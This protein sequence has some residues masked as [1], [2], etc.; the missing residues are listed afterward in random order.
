[1]PNVDWTDP[2]TTG[3][4]SDTANWTGLVGEIYPG[5]IGAFGD[6]VTIGASN[7]AYVVTFNV[8][9]ATVSSLTIEG[10]NG[11]PHP[12]ILRMTAGT[13]LNIAGGVTLF[14]KDSNASI[15][16]AGTLSVSGGITTA[17]ATP[18]EGI[19]T[20]GTDT[21]GG[22]LE[23]TGT[24]FIT[25][26][27]VFAISA[28]A[29][30]TLAF[31][32]LGGVQTAT[33]ITINNVNQTL[34]IGSLGSL[35]IGTTQ[36]VTDGTIV[37]A[38]GALTDVSGISFGTA[39]SSGSLSGYGTITG[40][41]TRSGSGAANTITAIGGNLT[42]STAI[43]A[44]SGL[45]FAIG[46]TPVSA[47]QL[48]ADPGDGNSFTFLGSDGELALTTGAAS[49]FNN[50]I[51]GLDVGTTLTPTN[52]VHILDDPTVT[53]ASGQVGSGTTGTVTLSNGAVLSLGGITNSGSGWFVNTVSDGAGGTEVFL[54]T[55][56]CYL[57]G[58][59][60]LTP[61]GEVCVE[62]LKIGDL[63]VTRFGAI[64]PIKWIG[65]QSYGARF[66]KTDRRQVP[67]CI[68]AG[69]LGDRQP[70]RDLFVSPGHSMLIDGHLVL[71]RFLVNG[72]TITQE[73]S[74]EDIHYFQIELDTHDCV[75]AE[76]VWSETFA[77]GP[78]LRNQFHNVAEFAA[79]YPD[80]GPPDEISLCAPRP[81]RGAKLDKVLRSV[82][83]R[84]NA[85][86]RPGPLQGAIDM[87]AAPWTIEGWAN[88][89]DHPELPVLLEILMDDQVIGTALACSYRRDLDKVGIGAGRCAFFVTSPVRLRPDS[90]ESLRIRR[91]SDH[92]EIAMTTDCVARIV[93]DRDENTASQLRLI[94]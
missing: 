88:D 5:Q 56:I 35:V 54:S 12:T 62:D 91:A 86:L 26:P 94:A 1:M 18:S 46:S 68:R 7:S 81:E 36:N 19:I 90:L 11:T 72:V 55:A 65:R 6:V 89:V 15:D 27:F 92:A 42:L 53:V 8:P 10:G 32:L 24:G 43:G 85:G 70:A 21:T 58:T 83:A 50:T 33:A 76:G 31:N 77:D 49:G 47:L 82:V 14:K 3:N 22:V 2:G 60:I 51:V 25:T 63:V 39:T 23:L 16:G 40:A 28:A 71:A 59:H 20:A 48:S 57:G 30:S 66:V 29:P 38:G 13:T 34:E 79:R 69:A 52:L 73:W 64:Q 80:H 78:G 67:V 44:N 61:T 17:G 41:L 4:W 74:P 84:A 87:V 45:I 93:G 37:M 75:I 9:S